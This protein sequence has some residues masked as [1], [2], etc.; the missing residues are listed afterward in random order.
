MDSAV[1]TG[2]NYR[3]L[4]SMNS[5][6]DV[7]SMWETIFLREFPGAGQFRDPEESWRNSYRKFKNVVMDTGISLSNMPTMAWFDVRKVLSKVIG[8]GYLDMVKWINENQDV[9][10]LIGDWAASMGQLEILKWA[11]EQKFISTTVK[12]NTSVP[13]PGQNFDEMAKTKYEGTLKLFAQTAEEKGYRDIITWLH[14][15][16]GITV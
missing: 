8:H 7:D 11:D 9:W 10:Y 15:E 1:L 4:S 16:K 13:R 5:P 6:C 12:Y 2:F 14:E 3:D